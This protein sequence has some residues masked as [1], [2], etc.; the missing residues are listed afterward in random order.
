MSRFLGTVSGVYVNLLALFL[1][2]DENMGKTM[3]EELF[4]DD[5]TRSIM[6]RCIAQD[7]GEPV[8]REDEV[9][10]PPLLGG[11]TWLTAFDRCRQPPTKAQ[12]AARG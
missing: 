6:N 12:K 4:R 3:A 5:Q 11:A 2:S 9:Q 7:P 10:L 8:S 1:S